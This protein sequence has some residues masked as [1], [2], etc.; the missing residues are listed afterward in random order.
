M[1]DIITNSFATLET[2]EPATAIHITYDAMIFGFLGGGHILKDALPYDISLIFIDSAHLLYNSITDYS[3][4]TSIY[5]LEKIGQYVGQAVG[6]I[7]NYDNNAFNNTTVS[8]ATVIPPPLPLNEK[9]LDIKCKLLPS[10]YDQ[11]IQKVTE[12]SIEIEFIPKKH[13]I[14]SE[15]FH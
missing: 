6:I 1:K 5:M 9:V 7:Y 11:Y 10:S 12:F 4:K 14:N 3:I 15:I 2:T 8:G 13:K